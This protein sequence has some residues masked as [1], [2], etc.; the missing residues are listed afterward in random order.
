MPLYKR[1]PKLKGFKSL[2]KETFD[3]LNVSTLDE[4]FKD[5]D[6]IT[7]DT[8]YEKNL[9][10]GKNKIKILGNGELNKSLTVTAS[11]FSKKA[12][13]KIENANGKVIVL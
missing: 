11:A 13:E 1:L 10:S 9:V 6:E 2:S 12:I 7:L 8:L 5:K 3:V 4:L